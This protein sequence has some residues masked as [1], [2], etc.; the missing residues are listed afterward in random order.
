MKDQLQEAIDMFGEEVDKSVVT[1]VLKNL[2]V[3]N[4][5]AKELNNEDSD[6]FHSVVAKLLFIMKCTRPDLEMVISFLMTRVSKSDEDNWHK[7]KRC[8]GFIK[9]TINDKRVIGADNINDLFVWVDAL[10]AIHDDMKGHTG[11]VMSLGTGILHG[12]S[13]KQKLNTRSTTESELVGVREYLPYDI[14]Q[15]HF[16]EH[17]GY[18]MMK[19]IVFQD[20]QSAIKME[21]NG[22][23]SCTVIRMI[24]VT[25][26]VHSTQL[27]S[28]ILSSQYK[29]SKI[30]E[31]I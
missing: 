2:F 27:R 26:S 19:N 7:L 16:Y 10:H 15:V 18:N 29:Y 14:W 8:L 20:N 24:L 22:R 23:N 30:C 3:I 25:A 21:V 13:S 5:E 4:S 31:L 1:P 12:K 17:Q 9:G 28:I 11:G 6:T